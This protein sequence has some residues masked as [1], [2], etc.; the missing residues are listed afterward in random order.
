MS[1]ASDFVITL[2]A[3]DDDPQNLEL[4]R[5]GL[6]RDDLQVLTTA[7]PQEGLDLVLR[8]R[9]AADQGAAGTTGPEEKWEVVLE[10]PR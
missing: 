7:D 8:R 2:V 9:G 3:V 6:A 4:I 5:E 10:G 1:S